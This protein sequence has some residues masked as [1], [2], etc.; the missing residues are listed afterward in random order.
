M[1]TPTGWSSQQ[2]HVIGWWAAAHDPWI[3]TVATPAATQAAASSHQRRRC[4]RGP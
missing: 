3:K 4:L 1:P 2:P